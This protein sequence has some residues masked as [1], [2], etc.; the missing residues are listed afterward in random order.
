MLVTP[1]AAAALAALEP[2]AGALEPAFSPSHATYRLLVRR[3]KLT[4]A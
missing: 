2:S 3:C 1:P 4:L